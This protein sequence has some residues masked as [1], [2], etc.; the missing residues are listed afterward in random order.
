MAPLTAENRK[1]LR[2]K[3]FHIARTKTKLFIRLLHSLR[4]GSANFLGN[5]CSNGSCSSSQLPAQHR[6]QNRAGACRYG[7]AATVQTQRRPNSKVNVWLG[8]VFATGPCAATG[9]CTGSGPSPAVGWVWQGGIAAQ[10]TWHFSRALNT[11]PDP[12]QLRHPL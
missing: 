3:S 12:A 4:V 7:M 1:K 6:W 8:G 10:G 9:T 5:N 11:S 2:H